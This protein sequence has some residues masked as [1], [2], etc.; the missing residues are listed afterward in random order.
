MGARGLGGLL[1]TSICCVGEKTEKKEKT[2]NGLM[3]DGF[4]E[5][6]RRLVFVILNADVDTR[7]S[8]QCID[9]RDAFGLDGPVEG[10]VSV[11]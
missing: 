3:P 8:E 5:V 10:R 11:L 7:R 2:N 9:A 1:R 6:V 4:G